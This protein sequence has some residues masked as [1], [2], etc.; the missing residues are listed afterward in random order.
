MWPRRVA[1]GAAVS[2]LALLM[3]WSAPERP[4]VVEPGAG[5]GPRPAAPKPPVVGRAVWHADEEAV[6]EGPARTPSAEAVFVHHTNHPNAYDCERDVPGLL[7]E[8]QRQHI[9]GRGW[10]DLGYNFVVDRCGTIYEGRAGSEERTVL[11]AHTKGFNKRSVG[12]AALG[13][14]GAGQ[15]VPDRML[16]AIAAV[17]AWKLSPGADPLGRVRM[18]STNDASLYPKGTEVTL[19]VIAGH[20]DGYATDCPGQAL[21]EALP[22][23]RERVARLRTEHAA[24]ASGGR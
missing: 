21:Y 5:S 12:I 8:M 24:R 6:R 9:E 17:A 11:G 23:L 14:F 7:R 10:D 20:R 13:T 1:Q 18:E 2:V 4:P 16:A 22:G 3:T 19:D 15:E